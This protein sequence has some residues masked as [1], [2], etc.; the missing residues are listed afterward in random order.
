MHGA[1]IKKTIFP[2]PTILSIHDRLFKFTKEI[3]LTN[4]VAVLM[5]LL[6]GK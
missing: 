3:V 2:C 4:F 5:L 6:G 1:T